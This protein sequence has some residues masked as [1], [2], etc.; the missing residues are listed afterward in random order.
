VLIYRS[1][2]LHSANIAQD[3]AFDNDPRR[4]R[5]TANT[6]FFYR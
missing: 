5:L 1:I 6:F 2:S 4:G 3:F